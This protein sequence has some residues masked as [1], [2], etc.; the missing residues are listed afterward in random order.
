MGRSIGS[1][2]ATCLASQRENCGL[3]LISPFDTMEH[4][5]TCKCPIFPTKLVLRNKF[6]SVKYA[7]SVTTPVYMLVGTKDLL[8]PNSLSRELMT[9]FPNEV[10]YNEIAGVGHN[11]I[12]DAD[13]YW[14]RIQGFLEEL[15]NL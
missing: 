7:P 8:V 13:E 4:I 15:Q 5:V 14:V 10:H 6:N 9:Y 11:T 3:I 2:V 1:S 12:D